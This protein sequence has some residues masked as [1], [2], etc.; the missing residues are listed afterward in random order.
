MED[1]DGFFWNLLKFMIIKILFGGF[2]FEWGGGGFKID[3][4][5]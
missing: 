3:L 5:F 1:L 4:K 2:F